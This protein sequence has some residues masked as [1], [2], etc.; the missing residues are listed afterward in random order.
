MAHLIIAGFSSLS[1]LPPQAA[2]PPTRSRRKSSQAPLNV[3]CYTQLSALVESPLAHASSPAKV[4]GGAA[5]RSRF[6]RWLL[7]AVFSSCQVWV[8]PWTSR[9]RSLGRRLGLSRSSCSAV[10]TGQRTLVYPDSIACQIKLRAALQWRASTSLRRRIPGR[11]P[12]VARA[13][14]GSFARPGA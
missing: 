3:C 9:P 14:I 6:R 13:P 11:R 1:S 8:L 7:Y 2:I 5:S 12:S 10:S 4:P